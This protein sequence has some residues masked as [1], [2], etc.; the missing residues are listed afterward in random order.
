MEG[1]KENKR[2]EKRMKQKKWRFGKKENGK[3]RR[4]EESD[5]FIPDCFCNIKSNLE[6]NRRELCGGGGLED[7]IR[8][9]LF[10]PAIALS[11]LA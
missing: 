8:W 3:T 10:S 11:H 4:E 2:N 1:G 7:E 6:R 5:L 9:A